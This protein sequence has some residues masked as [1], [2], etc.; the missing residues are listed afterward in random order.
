MEFDSFYTKF[1]G[2]NDDGTISATVIVGFSERNEA[3]SARTD[4]DVPVTLQA[5]PSLSLDELRELAKDAALEVLRKAE[6]FL[7]Q[8]SADQLHKNAQ[9]AMEKHTQEDSDRF[10][11]SLEL[12]QS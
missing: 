2:I 9:S 7:G 4:I 5:N 1:G 6:K 12:G 3:S 8:Y 10:R 11:R